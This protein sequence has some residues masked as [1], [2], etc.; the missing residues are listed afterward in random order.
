MAT[1]NGAIH[2]KRTPAG[3]RAS[4]HRSVSDRLGRQTKEVTKDLLELGEIAKDAAE[5]KLG[6]L[7]ENAAEY[8]EEGRDT[9]QHVQQ[10]VEQYIGERPLKS[11]LIA[12]GIGLL[13]GRFWMRR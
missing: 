10:S 11:I 3:N 5:E 7:R 8:C 1:G 6:Q 2:T 4:A 13:L 12:A 9:V